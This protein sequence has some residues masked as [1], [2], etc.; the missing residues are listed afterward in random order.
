MKPNTSVSH[1]HTTTWSSFRARLAHYLA[2]QHKLLAFTNK[3]YNCSLVPDKTT[4]NNLPLEFP[5]DAFAHG[6]FIDWNEGTAHYVFEY[7]LIHALPLQAWEPLVWRTSAK[8]CISGAAWTTIGYV[9]IESCVYL[10]TQPIVPLIDGEV[11]LRLMTISVQEAY[12]VRLA[13]RVEAPL[14]PGGAPG[15]WNIETL[16]ARS[17]MTDGENLMLELGT[18]YIPK[19]SCS[20]ATCRAWLPVTGPD[21]CLVHLLGCK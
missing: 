11:M 14:G 21:V 20:I 13:S 15:L 17:S 8:P 18:R 7:K 2:Q 5:N 9:E 19:R 10:D 12:S 1:V 6:G 4:V 3:P 16:E